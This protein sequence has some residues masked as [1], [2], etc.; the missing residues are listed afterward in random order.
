MDCYDARKQVCQGVKFQITFRTPLFGSGNH[1][2]TILAR[3]PSYRDGNSDVREEF[4][5]LNNWICLGRLHV[6][7]RSV[8]EISKSTVELPPHF[9]AS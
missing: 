1:V 5:A 9:L 3:Q 4:S 2:M 7:Q 8:L 6:C